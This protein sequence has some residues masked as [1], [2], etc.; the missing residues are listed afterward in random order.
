MTVLITD[1]DA[2]D[3]ICAVEGERFRNGP[4]DGNY[5]FP[6]FLAEWNEVAAFAESDGCTVAEIIG[7]TLDV[8]GNVAIYGAS[9]YD[10]Y[11]VLAT[12]EIVFSRRHSVNAERT[13]LAEAQGFRI[14]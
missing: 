8:D 1:A 5:S 10:R 11:F 14:Y 12:G 7:S 13:A 2:F 6:A 9:G 4:H 3:R